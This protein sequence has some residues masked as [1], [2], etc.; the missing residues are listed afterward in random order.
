MSTLVKGLIEKAAIRIKAGN[1]NDELVK[2]RRCHPDR[3]GG[4]L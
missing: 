1:N 3:K 2:S 4:I